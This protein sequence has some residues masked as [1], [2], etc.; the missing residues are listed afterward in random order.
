[1]LRVVFFLNLFLVLGPSKVAA[2][3]VMQDFAKTFY[4]SQAWKDCRASYKKS[5]GGL[6]E[7]CLTKGIYSP[8]EIVHHKIHLTPSNINNPAV[9]L[10]WNNMMLLCRDCHAE[11]HGRK[12]RY[13]IGDGGRVAPC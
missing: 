9:S 8:G 13:R 1:M 2:P 3:F 5:V 12:K 11:I 10:D 4:N 6:C 7:N